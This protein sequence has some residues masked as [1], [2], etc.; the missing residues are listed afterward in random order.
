MF[1]RSFTTRLI[2]PVTV[3]CAAVIGLGLTIDY[4]FSRSRI[5]SS[6]EENA[7][8][9][10]EGTVTSLQELFTGVESSARLLSEALT[11]LPEQA[12]LEQLARSMVDSNP[13]IAGASIVPTQENLANERGVYLYRKGDQLAVASAEAFTIDARQ[14]DWVRR[15]SIEGES[16]WS[17]PRPSPAGNVI[18]FAA[19]LRRADGDGDA[20]FAIAT[21]DLALS[22]L[23]NILAGLK[24]DRHGFGFLVSPDDV[25]VGSPEGRMIADP[26][27]TLFP[28]IDPAELSS[29][30]PRLADSGASTVCPSNGAPCELRLAAVGGTRWRLGIVFSVDEVLA[31]LRDYQLRVATVGILMLVV[32]ATLITSIT[33]RVTKPLIGLSAASESIARGD[34]DVPLPDAPPSDEVGQL[35]D[36]FDSM[37]RDLGSY[38]KTLEAETQRRG[39]LEGELAAAR[40]IQMAMVPQGGE[41]HF[42]KDRI[43]LWARVRPARAVGGD[44][45]SFES[46]DGALLFAIGDVS[47]KGVPA[48]LFMARAMSLIQQWELQS[49]ITPPHIALRQLNDALC[50]DNDAC[51]F[52][53]L[54]LGVLHQNTG[55]LEYASGGH[56]APILLREGSAKSV[57]QQRGPALGLQPELDFPTNTLQIQADDRLFFYTD[58]FDEAQNPQEEQLGEERLLNLLQIS[59]GLPL[60]ETGDDAFDQVDAFARSEPQADDMTLLAIEM[61]GQRRA[62]LQ[63]EAASLT[64]NSELPSASALWLKKHWNSLGLWDEGLH[65]LLLVLEEVTC[66]I[67]DHAGLGADAQIALSLERFEDRVEL[68]CIDAGV[69]F[70]PL[71]GA[72]GAEL[73]ATTEDAEIGGLGVHLI[74]R[75]TNRQFYRRESGRNILRMRL[76]LPEDQLMNLESG[77]G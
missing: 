12:Q 53:T 52:L 56:C 48:A 14:R 74:T 51:M 18:S 45:Y 20:I 13:N 62:P 75:L 4:Q 34:L 6:L 69:P 57:E 55:S 38:L 24:L 22:A 25:L 71:T 30:A 40:E 76:A 32:L 1:G 44:L 27:E 29:D 41:A 36:A 33:R 3:A 42:R 21:V 46:R 77:E 49:G 9:S 31:P 63:K 60:T 70:D 19:P 47:D 17:T 26:F 2:L 58:G 35:V 54:T 59:D 67:R 72:H 11:A 39:R 7:R 23:D 64:V 10:V 15:V 61:R 73:G 43:E 16:A 66:N 8:T 50:R 68:E 65:D 37:R 28:G 5:L